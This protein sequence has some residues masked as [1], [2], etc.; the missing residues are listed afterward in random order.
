MSSYTTYDLYS[1][2]SDI[3]NLFGIDIDTINRY[4]PGLFPAVQKNCQS[5]NN[6]AD[7]CGTQ[8]DN[9][10]KNTNNCDKDWKDICDNNCTDLVQQAQQQPPVDKEK[11]KKVFC[12]CKMQFC[13]DPNPDNC[14]F[15]QS[16]EIMDCCDSQQMDCSGLIRQQNVCSQ[17]PSPSPPRP[18]PSPPQPNPSPPQPNPSPPQPSPF[19]RNPPNNFSQEQPTGFFSNFSTGGKIAFISGIIMFILLFIFLVYY[20]ETHNK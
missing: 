4:V 20:L 16:G 5:P 17:P 10:C 7:C 14:D 1:H 18:N 12:D 19:K 2:A 9:I 13:Q 11:L 6:T 3:H 8:C 15:N